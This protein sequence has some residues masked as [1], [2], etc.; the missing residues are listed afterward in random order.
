MSRVQRQENE[1]TGGSFSY[2][3]WVRVGLSQKLLIQ[4]QK[5]DPE[6]V[7]WMNQTEKELCD[8]IQM[9]ALVSWRH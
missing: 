1:F 8:E 7:M 3:R 9:K 5:D 2:G 4:T 6:V